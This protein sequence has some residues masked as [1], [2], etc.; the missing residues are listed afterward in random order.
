MTT[1]FSLNVRGRI[2][3]VVYQKTAPGC[4]NI[5]GDKTRTLQVHTYVPHNYSNSPA[6]LAC[7]EKFRAGMLA[8]HALTPSERADF[9]HYAS[10]SALSGMNVF[11]SIQLRS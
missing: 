9:N 5:P 10:K 6:Q 2:G 11:L 8:W 7:R 3:N 4:G 1:L